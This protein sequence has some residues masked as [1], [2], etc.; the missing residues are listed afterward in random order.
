MSR[1]L[2]VPA[3]GGSQRLKKKN[4]KELSGQPLV[5]WTLDAVCGEFEKI[6]FTSDDDEILDI[7]TKHSGYQK[8]FNISKRPEHLS[9]NTSKVIDTV[10]HYVQEEIENNNR[11]AEV[12]LALPTCP[13]RIKEDVRAAK[14]LLYACDGVVSITDYEFPPELSLRFD[15]NFVTENNPDKPFANNNTRSQDWEKKYRPNGALYGC[16]RKMF[17]EEGH[18]FGGKIKGYYMSRERSVDIDT[19]VDFRLA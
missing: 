1:L 8:Y 14:K 13:L 12:W 2:V 10:W 18:F 6:I 16:K 11:F 19:E 9:T 5:Y 4:I 17:L 3:R 7:A 15:G